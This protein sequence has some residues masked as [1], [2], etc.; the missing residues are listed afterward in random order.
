MYNGLGD[1][2]DI[3]VL[4]EDRQ[5]VLCVKRAGLSSQEG[6][7]TE[8]L[9]AQCGAKEI[10]CV[11]R[12]DMAVGGLMVYAKTGPAAAELSWQIS[13]GGFLKEYL[14]VVQGGP[15][16]DSAVL[17]DLLY[18]DK[19][20]NKSYVV[21]RPRK[22]VREAELQ[23]SVLE[24]QEG[25]SLLRVR[26]A[27]G[28]THQIRVQFASRGMPLLGDVKYGSAHRECGIALWSERLR[29]QHPTDGKTIDMRISPKT[30][31]PWDKFKYLNTE[32][33]E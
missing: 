17:R 7:M 20:K 23:Y 13:G 9:R 22:G 8:L 2:M 16:E 19:A 6:G 5:I 11:H 28:R 18:R 31:F 3:N 12:L 26:L 15:A 30:A 27:T 10:Y 29:F 1:F 21:S 24:R 25:M 32:Q 4:Y 33:G 14:A